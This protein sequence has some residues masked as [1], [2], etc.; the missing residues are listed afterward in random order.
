[1][2][3]ILIYVAAFLLSCLSW[4]AGAEQAYDTLKYRSE[5]ESF[6]IM[7]EID[8]K[9]SGNT[10]NAIVVYGNFFGIKCQPC[11]GYPKNKGNQLLLNLLVN[12]KNH[13]VEADVTEIP[14]GTIQQDGTVTLQYPSRTK[15]ETKNVGKFFERKMVS[16]FVLEMLMNGEWP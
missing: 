6:F 3:L 10:L 8:G 14:V 5:T 12:G 1:M 7:G 4:K 2:K 16:S 15:I 9:T 11:L 13:G